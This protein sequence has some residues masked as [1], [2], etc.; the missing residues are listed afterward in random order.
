MGSA[1][2]PTC[3]TSSHMSLTRKPAR[4]ASSRAEGRGGFAAKAQRLAGAT[5]HLHGCR[6]HAH[7]KIRIA[8]RCGRS[9][10]AQAPERPS[11]A[12]AE[13][14]RADP[15]CST[16][17]APRSTGLEH[18]RQ[19]VEQSGIPGAQRSCIEFQ[20]AHVFT[21]RL[22]DSGARRRQ[23]PIQ[24][25]Q[26]PDRTASRPSPSTWRISSVCPASPAADDSKALSWTN[27]NLGTPRSQES[28]ASS[29]NCRSCDCAGR[30]DGVTFSRSNTCRAGD[31]LSCRSSPPKV[32][33]HEFELHDADLVGMDARVP[34]EWL[35]HEFESASCVPCNPVGK[36]LRATRSSAWRRHRRMPPM[37]ILALGK[38]FRS[39][40]ER[41]HQPLRP[42]HRPRQPFPRVLSL[43]KEQGPKPPFPSSHV[44][45]Y[46]PDL[47]EFEAE[48]S[49]HP[50][51]RSM[52][53]A[54]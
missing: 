36:L 31:G 7:E 19:K 11:P 27:R 12:G 9:L 35:G 33:R 22:L 47:P 21:Q 3:S 39:R 4:P 28:M 49:G 46:P 43:K 25:H 18:P 13:C 32:R 50:L 6:P 53:A 52:C 20:A 5:K 45:R 16:I 40:C 15:S 41:R 37:P 30:R 1:H 42:Y 10:S 48:F 29:I 38:E 34:E 26:R 44:R 24:G 2:G 23:S 54:A 14:P 8:S 51:N 17:D